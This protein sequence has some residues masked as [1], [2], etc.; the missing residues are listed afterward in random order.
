MSIEKEIAAMRRVTLK[1][2]REKHASSLEDMANATI[3][4]Y[5]EPRQRAQASGSPAIRFTAGPYKETLHSA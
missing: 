5:F 3:E 1:E 2:L 4:L